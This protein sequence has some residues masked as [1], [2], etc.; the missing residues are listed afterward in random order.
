[1]LNCFLTIHL[2]AYEDWDANM[3]KGSFDSL[4]TVLSI[5][6]TKW[7]SLLVITSQPKEILYSFRNYRFSGRQHSNV[8]GYD[9]AVSHDDF[10]AF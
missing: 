4:A 1:M 5:L 10:D 2:V 8:H 7:S 3:S 6:A 9:D